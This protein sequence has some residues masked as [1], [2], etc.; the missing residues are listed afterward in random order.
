MLTTHTGALPRP[1]YVVDLVT[2]EGR[3]KADPKEFASKVRE[4]VADIVG[5]QVEHGVTVL[6]DGEMSKESYS[7]YIRERLAGFDGEG[8]TAIGLADL[9]EYPA[10]LDRFMRETMAAS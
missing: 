7:T 2:V 8:E 3:A 9:V 4:G 5:K 10:Y 6:N 1:D